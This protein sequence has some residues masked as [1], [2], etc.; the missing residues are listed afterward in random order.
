MMRCAMLRSLGDNRFDLADLR[1][2]DFG[3]R[4]VEVDRPAPPAT[5]IQDVEQLAHQLEHRHERLVLEHR[6]RIAIGQDG[7]DRRVGH[8]RVTVDDAVVNLVPHDCPLPIHLHQ[9]R[10]HQ[11]VD[12]RIQAAESGRQL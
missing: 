7:V 1:Q 10:L 11:T 9:A 12:L 3:L 2:D 4:Q 5:T 6:F 8:P